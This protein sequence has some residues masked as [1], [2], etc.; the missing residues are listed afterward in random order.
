MRTKTQETPRAGA[1]SGVKFNR[2]LRFVMKK[3]S[4]V[5]S[6]SKTA[7]RPAPASGRK[8]AV[9]PAPAVLG[10]VAAASVMVVAVASNADSPGAA[11]PPV[12]L[13]RVRFGYF[14]PDA[15]EVFLA[16]S[17]N[18]WDRRATPLTRDA[19]GDW[20]VDVELPP[21]E[22]RYRLVVDGEWRDDPSAQ[23]TAQNPF[24]GYDAVLVVCG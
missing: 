5:S 9:R 19:L 3:R 20:S 13:Q 21:G 7:A 6:A 14:N 8:A 23:Q 17:F 22:Y 15:R 11:A 18:D 2:H 24:G 16:G 1:D 10:G 12:D 4:P